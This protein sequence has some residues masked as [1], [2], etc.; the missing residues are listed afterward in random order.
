M[1]IIPKRRFQNEFNTYITYV[2]F[3]SPNWCIECE[4]H[5]AFQ[6]VSTF[7]LCMVQVSVGRFKNMPPMTF[8]YLRLQIEHTRNHLKKIIAS[9]SDIP[10]TNK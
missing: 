4:K 5:C 1:Q 6:V 7:Y 2:V 8:L 10:L 9:I 3:L